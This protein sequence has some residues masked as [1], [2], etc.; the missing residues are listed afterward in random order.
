MAQHERG[1]RCVT[2]FLRCGKSGTPARIVETLVPRRGAADATVLPAAPLPAP[3]ASKVATQDTDPAD[4]ALIALSDEDDTDVAADADLGTAGRKHARK[5]VE[6]EGVPRHRDEVRH[7]AAQTGRSVSP[8]RSARRI[9]TL[10][11]GARNRPH[12]HYPRVK[13][14]L[15]TPPLGQIVRPSTVGTQSCGPGFCCSGST[16]GTGLHPG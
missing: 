6:R 13:V 11:P 16:P 15:R 14:R 10:P 5:A 7:R 4:E 9:A 3:D 12:S 1:Y 2:L 8:P